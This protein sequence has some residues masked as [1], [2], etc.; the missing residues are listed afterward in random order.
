MNAL[1]IFVQWF[2]NNP[3]IAMQFQDFLLDQTPEHWR[4]LEMFVGGTFSGYYTIK[5]ILQEEFPIYIANNSFWGDNSY[6]LESLAI[7]VPFKCQHAH[8]S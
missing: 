3:T 8:Q 1:V 6:T 7:L 5:I 2:L 4:K